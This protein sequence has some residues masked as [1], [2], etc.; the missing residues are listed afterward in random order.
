MSSVESLTRALAED[1][2]L[3]VLLLTDHDQIVRHAAGPRWAER[4][5]DVDA[6]VGR[7]LYELLPA[8]S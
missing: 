6:L 8:A 5:H 1:M 7:H 4:G 2:P 3:S